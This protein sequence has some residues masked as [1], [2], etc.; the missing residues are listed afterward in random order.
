MDQLHHQKAK[1][2][3]EFPAGALD[4]ETFIRQWQARAAK[5][6]HAQER[7]AQGMAA[8]MRAQ[9]RYGQEYMASH[10]NMMQ[11]EVTDAAHLSEQARQDIENF[12]ALVKEVSGEIRSGFAEAGEMLE[13]KLPREADA[14]PTAADIEVPRP[15]EAQ[16][17]EA[18]AEATEAKAAL[19]AEM[20]PA[21]APE[22]ESKFASAK[23]APAQVKRAAA[24]ETPK[25]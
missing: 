17:E 6:V 22:S 9:L 11:W 15:V 12:A 4:P 14:V 18:E 21:E 1:S 7:I 3:F 13:A 25:L 24:R 16:A 23:A 19:E 2:V 20:P 10:M 5:L 8:A